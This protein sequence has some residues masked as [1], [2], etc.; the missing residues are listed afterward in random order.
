MTTSLFKRLLIFFVLLMAFGLTA[1][2]SSSSSSGS[3]SGSGGG[4]DSAGGSGDGGVS[5]GGGNTNGD[6]SGVDGGGSDSGGSDDGG[7]IEQTER[8]MVT[9]RCTYAIWIQQQHMPGEGVVKMLPGESR[10]WT[11]P[12]EGLAATRLWP[13]KGCDDNGNN[14]LIGQSSPACP[15]DGGDPAP[16]N[17]GCAPPVDSKFEA[18]WACTLSPT[19]DCA[20]NPSAP[21]DDPTQRLSHETY[22]NMSAVDGYTFPFTATITDNTNS[23]DICSPTDCSALSMDQCPTHED[24]SVGLGDAVTSAYA[25]MSLILQNGGQIAGCYSPCTLMTYPAYGGLGLSNSSDEAVRYCCPTP[26]QSPAQCSSGPVET[27]DYVTQVRS[28]CHNTVYT[29]A[30]D[31]SDGLRQCSAETK[32]HIVFGP[33]CP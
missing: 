7:D 13:K 8:L 12:E 9:N 11:I 2:F 26:P 5:N 30:Y 28:M 10:Q 16:Y 4:T 19:S 29:Y 1:C 20:I 33:N 27:T 14:C 23:S 3:S 17:I 22:W 32:V 31:D 21:V 15:G 25:D 6:N 24:L 18:T